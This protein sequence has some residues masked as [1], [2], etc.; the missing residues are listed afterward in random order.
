MRVVEFQAGET[1]LSEGD[2]GDSAFYIVDGA[3]EVVIGQGAAAKI[4]GALKTGEVF[5]EMCLIDPGPRSATIVATAPTRCLATSY[6]EFMVAIEENPARAIEFMKTL[7]RR[8]RQMN[9]MMAGMSPRRRGLR[10]FYR[11]LQ[12]AVEPAPL[13]PEV[14]AISW[15]ML[16]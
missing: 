11:D 1:I 12:K 3:V 15:T 5:G 2:E 10:D 14:V 6:E 9:E 7:A 8:L 16:W 13:D 4:V